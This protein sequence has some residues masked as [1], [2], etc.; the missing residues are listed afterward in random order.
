MLSGK[1]KRKFFWFK[2]KK[3]FLFYWLTD[4]GITWNLFVLANGDE[5]DAIVEN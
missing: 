5:E 1:K 3:E 4:V 2:K